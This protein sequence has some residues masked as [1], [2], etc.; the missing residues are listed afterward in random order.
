MPHQ[1]PPARLAAVEGEWTRWLV[2]SS[3][4]ESLISTARSSR[5]SHARSPSICNDS[6]SIIAETAV[7]DGPLPLARYLKRGARV[8]E[9]WRGV[10]SRVMDPPQARFQRSQRRPATERTDGQR[11][12]TPTLDSLSYVQTSGTLP[13]SPWMSPCFSV[14]KQAG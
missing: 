2:H 7:M 3:R 6:N 12:R 1:K 8:I 14:V 11:W 10:Y 9:W 5:G 13:S 4:R